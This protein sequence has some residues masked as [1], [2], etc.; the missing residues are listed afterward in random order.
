MFDFD[1][2]NRFIVFIALIYAVVLTILLF[3][4]AKSETIF[5][6]CFEN[7]CIKRLMIQLTIINRLFDAFV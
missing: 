5:F 7:F 3:C 4:Y 6:C 2:I 1:L